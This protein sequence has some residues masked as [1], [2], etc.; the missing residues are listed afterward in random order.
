LAELANG[1][2]NKYP[3]VKNSF[4][5]QKQVFV[6][7]WEDEKKV[8]S[9]V[10]DLSSWET[11]GAASGAGASLIAKAATQLQQM[12]NSLTGGQD[13]SL[14]QSCEQNNVIPFSKDG[15]NEKVFILG[16]KFFSREGF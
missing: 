6:C 15:T 10:M 13:D 11:L 2:V 1:S 5:E 16:R 7:H 9:K 3:D 14:T 8:F 4:S 12:T